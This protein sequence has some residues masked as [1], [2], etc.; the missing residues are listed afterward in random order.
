MQLAWRLAGNR[1]PGCVAPSALTSG[2]FLA[3]GQMEHPSP[4]IPTF[5]ARG[6]ADSVCPPTSLLVFPLRIRWVTASKESCSVIFLGACLSL[7]RPHSDQVC[8]RDWGGASPVHPAWVVLVD[9]GWGFQALDQDQ[10]MWSERVRSVVRLATHPT[11]L[12]MRDKESK[13]VSQGFAWESPSPSGGAGLLRWVPRTA[14][15]RQCRRMHIS[16][17]GLE[18]KSKQ[19]AGSFGACVM[20]SCG[21]RSF[22]QVPVTLLSTPIHTFWPQMFQAYLCFPCLCSQTSHFSRELCSF[23]PRK[24]IGFVVVVVVS[25]NNKKKKCMYLVHQ[26]LFAALGIFTLG[27]WGLVPW[28]GIQPGAPA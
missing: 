23:E 21:T 13:C 25:F 7:L 20:R 8:G 12:E 18:V 17:W 11:P 3:F 2:L 5:A 10:S 26:V 22:W 16:W 28:S 24:A 1:C 15:A 14:P 4:R 6:R 27:M 9:V 19:V